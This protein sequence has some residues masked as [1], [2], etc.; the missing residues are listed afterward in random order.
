M[1][2]RNDEEGTVISTGNPAASSRKDLAAMFS[3][4]PTPGNT[5]SRNL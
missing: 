5:A 3:A 1:G 2:K 4:A